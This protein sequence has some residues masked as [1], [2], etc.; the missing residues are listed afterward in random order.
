MF[1]FKKQKRLRRIWLSPPDRHKVNH[2]LESLEVATD[3]IEVMLK[4]EDA[5]LADY[6]VQLVRDGKQIFIDACL[7]ND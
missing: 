7:L 2:L 3:H 1:G 6:T 4:D 5:E